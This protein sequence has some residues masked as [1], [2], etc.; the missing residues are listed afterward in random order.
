[1]LLMLWLV[2]TTVIEFVTKAVN[3]SVESLVFLAS[4]K[5]HSE[6]CYAIGCLESFLNAFKRFFVENHVN[7]RQTFEQCILTYQKFFVYPHR[8]TLQPSVLYSP[9]C[10]SLQPGRARHP[11]YVL[12]P[13]RCYR[14]NAGG[15]GAARACR[16]VPIH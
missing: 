3:P 7:L 16:S 1:M 15:C 14:P 2:L 6:N 4:L 11:D 5:E 13:W 12:S 8:V 9:V 10:Y